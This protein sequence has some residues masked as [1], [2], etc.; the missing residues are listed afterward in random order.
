MDTKSPRLGAVAAAVT[1][2]RHLRIARN[3]Q[4]AAAAW[5]RERAGAIVVCDGCSAGASSEV[6]ARLA[7]RLVIAGIVARLEAGK[8][9][10]DSTLWSSMRAE[11][12]DQ[13]GAIVERMAGDR[14]AA[15]HEHFLF[16]IV[17]A[18]WRGDEVA[19]WA[20]GDGAYALGD[21]ARTLGPFHDNQPPYLAYDLLGTH[22]APHFVVAD[23]GCGSVVVA[24]DGVA[25]LG[26]EGYAQ[27]A[28]LDR[29]LAHPDALRRQLALHARND[30]R[31]DWDARRIVRR[32]A[33]LQDD[34]AVAVLRWA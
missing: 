17:A 22:H 11:V 5:H 14:V 24:T 13:V 15:L 27:A 30:E 28:A 10:G 7:A 20:L 26:L 6:G 23:A 16:T 34:G 12:G 32:P 19:V 18:A 31:V 29:F 8:R 21:H 25:E 4:D 1:G 33:L 2:A 3:G 9:A